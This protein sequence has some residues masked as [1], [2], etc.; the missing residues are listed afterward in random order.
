MISAIYNFVRNRSSDFSYFASS[1]MKMRLQVMAA[2][3][4]TIFMRVTCFS[5]TI[6]TLALLSSQPW[7]SRDVWNWIWMISVTES[8]IIVVCK[9]PLWH[10][11]VC[12]QN[13]FG[14]KVEFLKLLHELKA[15]KLLNTN[16][17]PLARTDLNDLCPN[18]LRIKREALNHNGNCIV[19]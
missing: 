13:N 10:Q 11:N 1:I 3:R 6:G 7:W 2:R 4:A 5:I 9:L 17:Q 14:D 8:T 18:H 12:N 16:K 19:I 15:T